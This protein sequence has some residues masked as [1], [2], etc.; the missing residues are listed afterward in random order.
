MNQRTCF[1]CSPTQNL[2]WRFFVPTL[3][4]VAHTRVNNDMLIKKS[5]ANMYLKLKVGIQNNY[6]ELYITEIFTW[7]DL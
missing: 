6:S 5:Q 3:F 7:I 1:V 2:R 4:S